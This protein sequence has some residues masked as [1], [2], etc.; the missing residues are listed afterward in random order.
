MAHSWS[1]YR[2]IISEV[3]ARHIIEVSISSSSETV[4]FP[5]CRYYHC[6]ETYS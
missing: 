3:G 5:V 6:A 4:D 2:V 1:R